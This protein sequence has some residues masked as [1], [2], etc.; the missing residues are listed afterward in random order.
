MSGE[1]V[2]PDWEVI[3]RHYRAGLLS[4]REIAKDG[5]VTEGAIR[6]R[7]KRDQWSRNL[8]AKIQQ[9][10]DDLVRKATVRTASTQLTAVT[11]KEVVEG[12]A[13]VIVR[14][15]LSHR[16]DIARVKSLL[17]MLLAEAEHQGANVELYQQLGV[18]LANPD[19]RGQ[20]KLGEIYRKAMSL[21]SRVGVLKQ[22]TETLAMLIKLE[23]EAFGIDNEKA[24][25]N[26]IDAALKQMAEWKKANGR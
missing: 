18:M 7:A 4:L 12:N 17:I 22:I 6:K 3:E 14:I 26:P 11:E 19:E 23:R 13:D 8:A 1:K 2:T 10:A 20:D 9:R 24:T 15:K 25:E 16:T 21:P 5:G